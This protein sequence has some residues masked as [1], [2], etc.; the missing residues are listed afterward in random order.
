MPNGSTKYNENLISKQEIVE[1]LRPYQ[2][3]LLP[4]Q[5]I[6]DVKLVWPSAIS[7]TLN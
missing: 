7:S 1:G 6:V 4:K 3:N 5:E 2:T